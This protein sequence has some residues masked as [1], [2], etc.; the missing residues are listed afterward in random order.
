MT[1]AEGLADHARAFSREHARPCVV[2]DCATLWLAGVL[3]QEFPRYSA[4]Q[5]MTHLETECRHFIREVT[6]LAGQGVPVVVVSNEA[7]S[8]VVPAN[9]A[10]RHFRDALGVLN[11]GLSEA[12]AVTVLLMAGN[13]LCLKGAEAFL[14]G[15]AIPP[16]L[17]SDG[18]VP[19]HRIGAGAIARLLKGTRQ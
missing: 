4:R 12:S 17:A 19:L 3:T 11:R 10:G 5:L 18:L 14:P 6:G 15:P 16:A 13:P 7:G 2:V 9:A 1:S 8:G